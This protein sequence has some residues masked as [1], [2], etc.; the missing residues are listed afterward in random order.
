MPQRHYDSPRD[1]SHLCTSPTEI[2]AKAADF[3]YKTPNRLFDTERFVPS[4]EQRKR[5]LQRGSEA[6]RL[7]TMHRS[8]RNLQPLA[9]ANKLSQCR[10]ALADQ[11]GAIEA[12]LKGIDRPKVGTKSLAHSLPLCVLCLQL[13]YDICLSESSI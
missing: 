10:N 11:L 2:T 1:V 7:A 12:E 13:S 3:M 5:L 6:C 9:R 8:K 4:R